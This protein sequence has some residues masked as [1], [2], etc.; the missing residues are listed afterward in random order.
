MKI[1]TLLKIVNGT[2]IG[3]K[4]KEELHSFSIDTRT[5]NPKDVFIA[6]KGRKL[7]GY[8]FLD[9]AA[10]KGAR[11]AIVSQKPL[12]KWKHM[13][14]LLV[15]DTLEALHS[16]VSYQ[17]KQYNIP[18]IAVTGSVGK[19]TLKEL[20]SGILEPDYKVLKNEGNQNNH[21]GLPLTLLKLDSRYDVIVTELGMNHPNE[22][23]TLSRL[24]KPTI[25]LIT[26]IGTSHIGNLGSKKNI[27]KAKM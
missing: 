2:Y 11:I 27:L 7:D 23:E 13:G 16:I 19:S 9:E 5:L 24:C 8:D 25:S 12:K 15:K 21:I 6:I 14:I 26:N 4:P 1:E 10:Q 3:K 18:L 20:I 17:R 22:I